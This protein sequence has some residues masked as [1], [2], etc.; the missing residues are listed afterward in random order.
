MSERVKALDT[1]K[2]EIANIRGNI[3]LGMET[4]SALRVRVRQQDAYPIDDSQYQPPLAPRTFSPIQGFGAR[5][6]EDSELL[7][8]SKR[9]PIIKW[10]VYW[11]AVDIFDNWFKIIDPEKPEDTAL[12][13]A[14]QKVL[15]DLDAKRQLTRL[16]TFERRY[17]TAVL[18]CAY[19]SVDDE[20]WTTPIYKKNGD[21]ITG[22]RRL[23]QITPYSWA[24]VKVS[25]EFIDKNDESLRY[26]LP[27]YYE[28]TRNST[29]EPLKVHWSRAIHAAT[30][31]DEEP[32]E[33]ISVIYAIYDDATGFRNA[34]W[35]Q[36]E[37]LFRYGSGFPHFHFPNA[38]QKE[39]NGW[40]AAGR[41][42][43][44]N[45]RGFFVST[46]AGEDKETIEFIGVKGVTLDPSP[47][48]EMAVWN[49]SMASRIPQ[50][51]L[52]GVSAGRITG[53]EVNERAYFKFI[54]AEQSNTEHII[55]ELVDRIIETGQVHYQDKRRREPTK[56][57]LIHWNYPQLTPER[58][59]ATIDYLTE[60]ANA[61]STE[62]R[63]VNEVR[64]KADPKLPML[65]D[66]EGNIV[67]GIKR[68]ERG[69]EFS[70]FASNPARR[71]KEQTTEDKDINEGEEDNIDELQDTV[72]KDALK[73][74]R[75]P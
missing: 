50:D 17:G 22:N 47:Y 59:R 60:R 45:A 27:E 51:I 23:L 44:V 5:N 64:A 24:K 33:G 31:L 13:D 54:N 48:N 39:V 32:F 20:S 66:D 73:R 41:F 53:S 3:E 1:V 14:V 34:R 71:T 19:A 6:I 15:L 56:D 61:E 4:V 52:K 69:G 8:A 16:I 65:P 70:P 12:D 57:Y 21:L 74:G 37:T 25:D 75:K 28:I 72:L 35:A 2:R 11:V 9:E 42:Q 43:N 7:F 58:D 40:I 38:T 62:Y 29:V 55:R 49:L 10:L 36:Y 18:L 68:L 46:G 30:R 26:G 63:T 67:L